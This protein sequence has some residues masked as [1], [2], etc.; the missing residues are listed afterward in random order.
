M[1]P[2]G[3]FAIALVAIAGCGSNAGPPDSSA[4]GTFSAS[5]SMHSG[6]RAVSCAEI[7]AL[8]VNFTIKAGVFSAV[9]SVSCNAGLGKT[10]MLGPG[11][12]D[13]TVELDGASGPI[14]PVK[15]FP[16]A[17][18]MANQDNPLGQIDFQVDATGGLKFTLAATGQT[19]NCAG[20]AGIDATTL[21]VRGATNACQPATFMIAAGAS[22][23]A[24]TYTSDCNT[25]PPGPC[26]E[27]DQ[28]ITVTG[29]NSGTAKILVGGDVGGKTCW[30]ANAQES[31]PSMS[32]VRDAG[33]IALGYD[34]TAC[35]P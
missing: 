7:S 13:V 33:A 15:N 10:R 28:V 1:P 22:T 25:L 4:P 14:A 29:V 3:R 8:S 31:V 32:A 11:A 5:W 21:Q 17:V 35:P 23:P 9:D 20:G 26:I 2:G 12:Y 24:S 30:T 16:A 34:H 6:S 19:V 18:L 27:Q